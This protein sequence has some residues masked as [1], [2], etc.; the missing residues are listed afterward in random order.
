MNL[1]DERVLNFYRKS[2][3]NIYGDIEESIKRIKKINISEVYPC[4]KD[5]LENQ[6]IKNVLDFGCGGGWFANTIAY[7]YDFNVYGLDFN[8]EAIKYSQRVSERMKI[9]TQLINS[10][11]FKFESNLKFD[12]ITSLGVLHHTHDCSKAIDQMLKFGSEKSFIFLGLYH[13]YGRKPFLDFVKNIGA[14][15]EKQKFEKYKIYH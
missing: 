5:V 10:D 12:L 3:F 2:P 15:N 14:L 11:L 13:K 4:L 1:I 6:K 7:H 9:K 8:E